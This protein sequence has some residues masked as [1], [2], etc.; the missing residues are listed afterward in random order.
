MANDDQLRELAERRRRRVLEGQ[1][2]R[3]EMVGGGAETNFLERTKKGPLEDADQFAAESK[4]DLMRTSSYR[5]LLRSINLIAILPLSILSAVQT[6]RIQEEC[7]MPEKEAS[8]MSKAIAAA[9]RPFHSSGL[10]LFVMMEVIFGLLIHW[11]DILN[12]S[13]STVSSERTILEGLGQTFGLP[14]VLLSMLRYASQLMTIWSCV[15]WSVRNLFVY[16][17]VYQLSVIALSELIS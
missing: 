9:P 8:F 13:K 5:H 10:T 7:W 17:F 12:M 16:L 3:M 1:R 15:Q 14:S 2:N 6:I 4:K 11:Q